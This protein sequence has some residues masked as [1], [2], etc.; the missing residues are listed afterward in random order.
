MIKA[1]PVIHEMK[2]K[3]ADF[4]VRICLTSQHKDMLDQMLGF[5]EITPDYDLNIMQPGQTLFDVSTKCLTGLEPVVEDFKPDMVAVIGD[6]TSALMGC[7]ASLYNKIKIIH[8]EAGL[9]SGQKYAP[10]PEEMNRIM[11]SHMADY[12]FAPTEEARQNLQKEGLSKNV[13]VVGN[14][15]IDALRD[16]VGVVRQENEMYR[17]IFSEIDFSK[18]IILVTCH[19][20][21]NFGEPIRN[22]FKAL[23][24][25]AE[26]YNDVQLVFPVHPNPSVGKLAHEMLTGYKNIFLTD[27]LGYAEFVWIMDASYFIITD[28][29]GVQEEAPTLQKPLLVLRDVTERP[30]LVKLGISK[31]VGSDTQTIV[32]AAGELLTNK[33]VYNT[34][35]GKDNPYGDGTAAHKIVSTL[36]DS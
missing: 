19:R 21:E 30:E 8:I 13:F 23:Q 5:F 33:D 6:T 29:G 20:R 4:D 15:V 22:I 11:I 7:I 17:K 16:A 12:H 2:S 31:L 26:N 34:M 1:A 28:S 32:Q 24:S 35:K 25:I 3:P 36:L 18:K 9:R 10:F 27:P 14:T